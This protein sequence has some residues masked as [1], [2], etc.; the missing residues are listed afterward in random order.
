MQ[1][2]NVDF[3]E[4]DGPSTQTV[5]PLS[6]WKLTSDRTSMS[7]NRFDTPATSRTLLNSAIAFLPACFGDAAD[8]TY[9]GL[10]HKAESPVQEHRGNEGREWNV[11][12]RLD[13]TGGVRQFRQRDDGEEGAILGDLDLLI[14]DQGPRR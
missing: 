12:S 8:R 14:P 4:P 1:R 3:P 5:S 7:P 10:D 9:P 2:S 11:M 6:I 13:G